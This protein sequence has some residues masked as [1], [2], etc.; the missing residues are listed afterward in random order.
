MYVKMGK[1][2]SNVP[3]RNASTLSL[4]RHSPQSPTACTNPMLRTCLCFH[5][6]VC[7][8]FPTSCTRKP[9]SVGTRYER[10]SQ[11]NGS[12]EQLRKVLSSHTISA[13][14]ISERY[15]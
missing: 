14:N 2:E 12:A 6:D 13:G 8:D 15:A 5:G 9:E 10:E 7:E 4:E 11:L 1:P 3:Q